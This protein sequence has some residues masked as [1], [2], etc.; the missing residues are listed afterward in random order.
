MKLTIVKIMVI[1]IDESTLNTPALIRFLIK[2]SQ[3]NRAIKNPLPTFKTCSS[4]DWYLVCLIVS[5]FI[6]MKRKPLRRGA[7]MFNGL[8]QR[9]LHQFAL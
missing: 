1:H 7:S 2:Y 4:I 9:N 6:V 8:G 3:T 5:P